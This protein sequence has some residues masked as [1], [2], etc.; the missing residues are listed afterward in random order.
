MGRPA[1]VWTIRAF[2]AAAAAAAHVSLT[3]VL[4][5]GNCVRTATAL[6][7]QGTVSPTATMP[8]EEQAGPG[9][10][11]AGG[12]RLQKFHFP[13]GDLATNV[14]G[15]KKVITAVTFNYMSPNRGRLGK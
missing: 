6:V 9:Q 15:L 5:T 4:C 8:T 7:F 2:T 10:R 13:E 1:G 3:Q 14:K 11:S 12:P